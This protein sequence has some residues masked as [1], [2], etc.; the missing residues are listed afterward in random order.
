MDPFLSTLSFL[1]IWFT[2]VS[3][4]TCLA[5]SVAAYKSQTFSSVFP[6]PAEFNLCVVMCFHCCSTICNP[7]Y[8]SVLTNSWL[9]S[10][11]IFSCWGMTSLSML[12]P[13]NLYAIRPSVPSV[14]RF[15]CSIIPLLGAARMG[16]SYYE[17]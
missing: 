6:G 2:L 9:C 14:E 12:S 11:L 5:V 7:S 1:D 15:F 4:I 16:T 8:Y 3:P 17:T 13:T 10:M